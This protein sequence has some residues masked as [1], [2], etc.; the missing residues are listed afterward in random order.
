MSGEAK[1]TGGI[2]ARTALNIPCMFTKRP[3]SNPPQ[4]SASNV[5]QKNATEIAN[6]YC[7]M[8]TPK[9]PSQTDRVML[10]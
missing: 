8:N 1:W 2:G 3:P 6:T 5:K 9:Y 4:T 7:Q 10:L